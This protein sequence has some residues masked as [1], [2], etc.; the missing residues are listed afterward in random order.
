MKSI[1]LK[2]KIMNKS[3]TK[4]GLLLTTLL[5]A[6]SSLAAVQTRSEGDMLYGNGMVAASPSQSYEITGPVQQRS[7]GYLLWELDSHT[8]SKQQSGDFRLV[9]DRPLSTDMIYG[10]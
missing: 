9:D 1:N 2:G 6:G 10:S 8:T 7:E 3:F 5:F 4:T